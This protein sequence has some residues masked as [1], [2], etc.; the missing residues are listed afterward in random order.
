MVLI[1]L[2]LGLL[3]IPLAT[4]KLLAW[5][6]FVEFLKVVAMFVVMVNVLRTRGRLRLL[7]LLILA[8]SLVLS[9]NAIMDYR[10]GRMML[11]GN[12]IAGAIGGLFENPND[13][14]LHMVTFLP[15]VIV[16]GLAAKNP[17]SKLVYW[18]AALTIVG[19]TV[20]TFSR[21]GFL[22]L[23]VVI[24]TLSW[25]LVKQNRPIVIV[26]VGLLLAGFLVLAPGAYRDRIST[27]ADDSANARTGELKRS[28]YITLRHPIV[29]VGMDNFVVFS[30]TAHA[31]HNAYTQVSS[32]IGIPAAIIYV[33]F[34]IAA[35]KRVKGIPHPREME[36]KKKELSYLAIGIHAS[37]IGYMVTSFFASVAYLWYVYYLAAYA[38][39]VSRFWEATASE[40]IVSKPSVHLI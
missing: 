17:F 29:G 38:I 32:E 21:G 27:T 14:A 26:V 25:R 28:L 4:D 20:V 39:S 13:L 5:N 18:L 30:N 22:G 19:G 1:L 37:L 40:E 35:V 23:L 12:R 31:T 3:S 36:G 16:L 33:M 2:V 8:A 24:A 7:W 11:G 15:I 6:S 10:A 34:L 9:V